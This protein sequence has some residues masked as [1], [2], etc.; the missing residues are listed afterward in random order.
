CAREGA[1]RQNNRFDV[2]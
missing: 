1:F 2:W